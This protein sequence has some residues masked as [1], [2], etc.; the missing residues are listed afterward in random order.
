MSS[1][2]KFDHDYQLIRKMVIAGQLSVTSAKCWIQ[3]AGEDVITDKQS[4][5]LR[6]PETAELHDEDDEEDEN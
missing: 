1:K 2:I 5:A 3:Q 4:L 6:R